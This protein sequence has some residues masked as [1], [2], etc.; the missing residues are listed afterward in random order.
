M[1]VTLMRNKMKNGT[2][3]N[4]SSQNQGT[5]RTRLRPWCRNMR[6]KN[7]ETLVMAGTQPLQKKRRAAQALTTPAFMAYLPFLK[8]V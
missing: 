3:K 1:S 5:V 2:A 8:L 7:P 4:N 6:L